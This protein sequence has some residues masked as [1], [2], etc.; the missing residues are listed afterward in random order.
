MFTNKDQHNLG[1]H[2]EMNC[3]W[4]APCHRFNFKWKANYSDPTTS[5]GFLKRA[6]RKCASKYD[7][8][9]LISELTRHMLHIRIELSWVEMVFHLSHV[10]EP[11]YIQR[12]RRCASIRELVFPEQ[13]NVSH[14]NLCLFHFPSLFTFSCYSTHFPSTKKHFVNHLDFGKFCKTFYFDIDRSFKWMEKIT[15]IELFFN[16]STIF[17]LSICH[18]ARWCYHTVFA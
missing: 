1:Q 18:H 8:V 15:R 10:I 11:L 17:A 4:S 9:T 2:F 3:I 5:F 13:K 16:Y 6:L 7:E 14:S 12:A